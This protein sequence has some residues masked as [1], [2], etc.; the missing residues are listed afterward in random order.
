MKEYDTTE[1]VTWEDII[2]RK[3]NAAVVSAR[4]RIMYDLYMQGHT[5]QE[6]GKVLGGRTPATIHYGFMKIAK[7]KEMANLE[8]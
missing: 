7:E 6:I 3:R 5:F 8:I 1:K 2:S 4:Q